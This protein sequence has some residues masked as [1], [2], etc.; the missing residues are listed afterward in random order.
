MCGSFTEPAQRSDTPLSSWL[1]DRSKVT[2]AQRQVVFISLS[3]A[4]LQGHPGLCGL[5][6]RE[7]AGRSDAIF[8]PIQVKGHR[9]E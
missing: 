4:R 5:C 2:G 1:F 9:R 6:S 8:P 3:A 7:S